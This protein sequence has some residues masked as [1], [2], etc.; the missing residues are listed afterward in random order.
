MAGN[1][2]DA[3]APMREPQQ[4]FDPSFYRP[5]PEDWLVA[6]TDI[7]GSTAAVGAGKHPTVNFIAASG[8]AALANLCGSIPYYFGGDG[9]AALVPPE[10][11]PEARRALART[12]G[13]ARRDF[14]FDLRVA[15]LPVRALAQRGA[16]VLV[17]RY[18]VAAGGAHAVF[19]GG[20]CE[21]LE[22]AV[23]GRGVPV[24]AALAAIDESLDDGELPDLTGLSCRFA[25]LKSL[26]GRMISLV[27]QGGDHGR[28]HRELARAAGVERLQ[29][30]SR[31]N[32]AVTW[33]PK[34]LLPEARARRGK[35]P[36]ALSV[37]LVGGLT[38]LSYLIFRFRLRIGRFSP[39][40][41]MNELV[42]NAV[43]FARADD[44]LCLVFDCPADRVDAVRAYLEAQN[45]AGELCYGM[46][47]AD[48]AVMTCFVSSAVEGRHVHFI[49]GG[50]GGYTRASVGL[51]QQ[52]EGRVPA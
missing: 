33:P 44:T 9:A 36:L 11:E 28:L 52:R 12:R 27:V 13:F 19:L 29:A 7:R 25:P 8:I 42:T 24:L 6:F 5:A 41:Y 37:L 4:I 26:R 10:F 14:N 46:H 18:E 17:G 15:M 43:D 38:L 49:D 23:K 35:K 34:G 50:D 2:Y 48:F 51:K 47:S 45:R 31:D 40:R 20:G 3:L 30:V 22:R 39:E 1:F 21:R 16:N 32:L